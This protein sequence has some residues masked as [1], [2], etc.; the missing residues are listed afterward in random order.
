MLEVQHPQVAG[1][2]IAIISAGPLPVKLLP[3]RF[4]SLQ[5]KR[6]Q[7]DGNK[8]YFRRRF[9]PT[10]SRGYYILDK[11]T[12]E[13]SGGVKLQCIGLHEGTY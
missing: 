5:D 1:I 9:T 2:A 6:L 8:Y 13:I 4:A 12:L 10:F 7:A 3:D 11:A